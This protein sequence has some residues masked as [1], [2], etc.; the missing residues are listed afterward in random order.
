MKSANLIRII[1]V[2]AI[3][4]TTRNGVKIRTLN[5]IRT[6]PNSLIM[7]TSTNRIVIGM[8]KEVTN[9]IAS[10]LG[11]NRSG[12]KERTDASLG[13]GMGQK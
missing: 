10:S 5:R 13:P 12:K 8:D 4:I 3:K 11:R 2:I 1:S 9:D 6:L 7:T